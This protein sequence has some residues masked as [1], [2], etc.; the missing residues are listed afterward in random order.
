MC[1]CACCHGLGTS[2]AR[3]ECVQS[4]KDSTHYCKE[5]AITGLSPSDPRNCPHGEWQGGTCWAD[6]ASHGCLQNGDQDAAYAS[7]YNGNAGDNEAMYAAYLAVIAGCNGGNGGTGPGTSAG[8]RAEDDG[9]SQPA[10][11]TCSVP[12][13]RKGCVCKHDPDSCGCACCRG[14]ETKS[15]GT[16]CVQRGASHPRACFEK[17]T[18][19]SEAF[20]DGLADPGEISDPAVFDDDPKTDPGEP[21]GENAASSDSSSCDNPAQITG[22]LCGWDATFT[23]LGCARCSAESTFLKTCTQSSSK[24]SVES[25]WGQCSGQIS[26]GF[27]GLVVGVV[28]VLTAVAWAAIR[29]CSNRNDSRSNSDRPSTVA[30]AMVK[31]DMVNFNAMFTRLKELG[32]IRPDALERKPREIARSSVQML[33][34]LGEGAF[35]KVWKGLLEEQGSNADFDL[36]AYLVAIKTVKVTKA[37]AVDVKKHNRKLSFMQRFSITGEMMTSDGSIDGASADAIASAKAADELMPVSH[38]RELTGFLFSSFPLPLVNSLM[39]NNAPKK[40]KLF[41]TLI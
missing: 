31:K 14:L 36:P 8:C 10:S 9:S 17:D 27:V 13:D 26:A 38:P 1:V 28:A 23:N 3:N 35:G 32:A 41:C 19:D 24:D 37:P 22:D 34:V 2:N 6:S 7:V 33:Q 4:G 40:E 12:A 29:T 39:G 11:G 30:L 5:R 25:E 21:A 16:E 20:D 18:S 15:A